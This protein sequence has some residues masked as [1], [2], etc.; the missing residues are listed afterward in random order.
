MKKADSTTRRD[1]SSGVWKPAERLIRFL[2]S[3]RSIHGHV[4]SAHFPARPGAAFSPDLA[5]ITGRASRTAR[6]PVARRGLS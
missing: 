1:A 4:G 3:A 2:E 6:A 5:K